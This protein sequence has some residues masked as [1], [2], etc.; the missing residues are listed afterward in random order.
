MTK[1]FFI[2]QNLPL[3]I[4]ISRFTSQKGADVLIE[5]LENKDLHNA[6]FA[7]LGNGPKEIADR[8]KQIGFVKANIFVYTGFNEDLA[9]QLYA[10][11]D[12][13]L[14]P[15]RFEPCGLSQL[16]AMKYGTIP[17]VNRTGGLKD[18]VVDINDG[19]YGFCI[20][21]VNADRLYYAI[22][23]A[24]TL[25]KHKKQKEIIAKK[26]MELNFSWT[27]SAGEYIKIYKD[28]LY[29]H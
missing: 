25:Y 29:H 26:C 6:A 2:D 20:D 24:I 27:K 5:L 3:F 13:L 15:S 18:T 11:G 12:F 1:N 28:L 19:G 4:F 10:A 22:Q 17:I 23:R 14:M 21:E 8:F 7:I 16:I 9:H